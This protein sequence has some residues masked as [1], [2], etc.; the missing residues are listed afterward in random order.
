MC[1]CGTALHYTHR[2]S[3]KGVEIAFLGTRTGLSRTNLFVPADQLSNQWVPLLNVSLIVTYSTRRGHDCAWWIWSLAP[4]LRLILCASSEISWQRRTRRVCLMLITS[5]CGTRERQS[6][7]PVHLSTPSPSAQ[8]C[9]KPEITDSSSSV[10]H[11]IKSI[12]AKLSA[13]YIIQVTLSW[14]SIIE[15]CILY[16]T[17]WKSIPCL[18]HPAFNI[19]ISLFLRPSSCYGLWLLLVSTDRMCSTAHLPHSFCAV[20]VAHV[21]SAGQRRDNSASLSMTFT[22]FPLLTTTASAQALPS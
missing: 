21:K 22:I 1:L 3:D 13:S 7:S 6:R 14:L 12:T 4:H 5:R 11:R 20:N 2:N 9:T 17:F 19:L 8:V 18:S 10:Q 16:G 15:C